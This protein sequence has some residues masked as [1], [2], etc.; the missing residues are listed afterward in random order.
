MSL[1]Q[2]GQI[3]RKNAHSCS[4]QQAKCS[5]AAAQPM[6][7]GMMEQ[8]RKTK[9]REAET[10]LPL[11]Y[12]EKG[13]NVGKLEAMQVSGQPPGPGGAVRA[14]GTTGRNPSCCPRTWALVP[15]QQACPQATQFSQPREMD[16]QNFDNNQGMRKVN[17]EDETS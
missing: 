3:Y 16:M 4:S 1:S 7:E 15:L 5:S 11:F 6:K 10:S 17:I 9:S 8:R 2:A 14:A 12:T 13:N